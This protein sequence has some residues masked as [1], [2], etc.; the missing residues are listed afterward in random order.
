LE[1][2]ERFEGRGVYYAA[3]FVESQWCGGEEVMVIGGGNSAGQAAVFL[4]KSARRVY[5][6]FR[7][8]D[9]TRSMS[10]Y[11]IRRIEGTPNI[12]MRPHTEIT[13]LEG[14]DH[15]ERVRCRDN[16]TEK[17]ETHVIRHVFVMSGAIPNTRW[18]DGCVT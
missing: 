16:K 2:L 17:E 7:A 11:L 8:E 5:L 6:I 15:L 14:D 1:N 9:L 13:A 4:A 12:V 3:S 10:R 18:L